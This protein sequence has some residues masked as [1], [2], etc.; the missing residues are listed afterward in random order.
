VG[1]MGKDVGPRDVLIDWV[2]GQW[3]DQISVH[4]GHM[5]DIEIISDTEARGIWAMED[6][7]WRPKDH[8]LSGDYSYLHG[9]GHYR[10]KYVKLDCGWRILE[11][12]LTRLRVEWVKTYSG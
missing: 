5:P 6:Q 9:W 2:A 4:H 3:G 12:E 11:A 1:E 7:I 10:E 8:P